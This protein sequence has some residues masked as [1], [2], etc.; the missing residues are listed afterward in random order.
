MNY[1]FNLY[2]KDLSIIEKYGKNKEELQL[3]PRE[4]FQDFFPP[5]LVCDY[6]HWLDKSNNKILLRDKLCLETFRRV[7]YIF[8][9]KKKVIFSEKDDEEFFFIQSKTYREFVN[10][11]TSRLEMTRYVH[12]VLRDKT[13][14]ITLTRMSLSFYLDENNQVASRDFR[15]FVV[16]KTQQLGTLIGLRKGL[17]LTEDKKI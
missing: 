6:S 8:D 9:I 10:K 11:I 12:V 13:I 5:L 1:E 15:G 17:V 7:H 14:W 2:E 3:I 4:I 16:N